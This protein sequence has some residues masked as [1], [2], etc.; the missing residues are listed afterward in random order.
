MLRLQLHIYLT[1][2]ITFVFVASRSQALEALRVR[3]NSLEAPCSDIYLHDT[4]LITHSTQTPTGAW[5]VPRP[6]GPRIA[7]T[8][9][10]GS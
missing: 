5:G 4:N 10:Y 6:Q 1:K 2:F 9:Y 8:Y 3:A 7:W